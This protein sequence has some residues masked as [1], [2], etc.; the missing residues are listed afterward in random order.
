M[1]GLSVFWGVLIGSYVEG[2]LY[3]ATRREFFEF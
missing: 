2:V 1:G 3:R